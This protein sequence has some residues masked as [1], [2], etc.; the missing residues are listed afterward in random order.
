MT[1]NFFP[2]N[3]QWFGFAKES[4]YGTPAASP[5]YFVP[6]VSP[7][8]T[9]HITTLPDAALRGSMAKNYGLQQGLRY[10]EFTYQTY[11]YM[12][13]VYPHFLAALGTADAVTG[14]ADP[15]THKTALYNG[16]GSN[17]AQPPS[18]TVWYFDAAGKCWQSAGCVS[19]NLALDVKADQLATIDAGWMGLPATAVTPPSNT[20]TG[21]PPMPSW[22]ATITVAGTSL[23]KYSDVKITLKRA[24]EMIPTVTG[25]QSP[26]AIYCGEL[27]VTGDLTGVYQN[28]TDND[29]AAFLANTQ[30]ALLVKVAPAGDAVHSLTLQMSKTAYT[31]SSISGS[32][33]WMEVASKIEALANTT[34]AL[35]GGFSPAQ[36]IFL[37]NA[38]AAF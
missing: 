9:P 8:W 28:S 25:T 11:P 16:S 20:P 37:T 14:S 10:D 23:S 13:S 4:S 31:D 6:M 3:L 34:D 27:D 26:F 21:N 1:T 5:S 18:F 12:D 30:A 15:W 2:G 32:N 22:N 33:K 38:S 35:G 17:A 19:S 7:K 29:L 24:T 36:A